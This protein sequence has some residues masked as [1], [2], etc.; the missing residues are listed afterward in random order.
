MSDMASR[1]PVGVDNH[2]KIPRT[3][4]VARLS[5]NEAPDDYGYPGQNENSHPDLHN[6][7][8][9]S[10]KSIERHALVDDSSFSHD[11]SDPYDVDYSQEAYME[12]PNT[13]KGRQ[14]RVQ[15]TH[16][17]TN[18]KTAMDKMSTYP[19][20]DFDGIHHSLGKDGTINDYQAVSGKMWKNKGLQH[21]PDH[22]FDTV[23]Q[24][25]NN[26]NSAVIKYPGDNLADQILAI[27]GGIKAIQDQLGK[28]GRTFRAILDKVYKGGTINGDGT[29]T[30]G[31]PESWA[32]IPIG[33]LNILPGGAN[34]GT[35]SAAL[36]SRETI[37]PN[38]IIVN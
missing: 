37:Q 19:D 31:Q 8:N 34:N 23:D 2:L 16:V 32:K 30:W 3:P 15:N 20:T 25:K 10:I 9:N 21:V 26:W 28:D 7:E 18:N 1:Y 38:D 4:A 17:F 33:N 29:I 13:K 12:H 5:E 24:L 35:I 36:R 22:Y 27:L 14:L 6:A 11:H